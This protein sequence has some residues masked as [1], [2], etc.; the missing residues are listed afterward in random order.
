VARLFADENFPLPVVNELRILGHD[1]M[2]IQEA[3]M[4]GSGVG[5]ADVLAHAIREGRAVLTLN[6]KHF[7][8]LHRQRGEH[9]GI[10][11]CTSDRDF[12][13]QGRR[14]HLV[15]GAEPDIS[16]QLIRINRPGPDAPHGSDGITPS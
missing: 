8:Q 15:L 4:A 10:V 7:I 1:V 6:R 13:A 14:I 5:D 3:G 16:N 2:T 9:P 12:I 11:A